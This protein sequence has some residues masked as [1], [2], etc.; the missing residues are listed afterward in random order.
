MCYSC[1]YDVQVGFYDQQV[2]KLNTFQLMVASY[3]TQTY[4]GFFY[5]KLHWDSADDTGGTD[6]IWSGVPGDFS[7]AAYAGFTNGASTGRTYFY[8]AGSG[9]NAVLQ[10]TSATG[11]TG[12]DTIHHH[13]WLAPW[14]VRLEH[15]SRN[16]LL[17]I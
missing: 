7:G 14:P 5:D 1:L 2:S 13:W 11:G 10:L 8:L 15:S 16:R 9:S 4:T 17:H 12:A 6:G 3:G